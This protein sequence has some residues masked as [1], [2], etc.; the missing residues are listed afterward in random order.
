MLVNVSPDLSFVCL[1]AIAL[2]L[3][4]FAQMLAMLEAL[5][6]GSNS[7]TSIFMCAVIR[8]DVGS[9]SSDVSS[10]CELVLLGCELCRKLLVWF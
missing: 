5:W 7:V 4:L 8:S 9:I 1:D 3:A 2:L 10:G 6:F